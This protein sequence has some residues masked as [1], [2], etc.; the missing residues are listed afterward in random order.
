MC[1]GSPLNLVLPCYCRVALQ[2]SKMFTKQLEAATPMLHVL[3]PVHVCLMGGMSVAAFLAGAVFGVSHGALPIG[4]YS[5]LA[6]A[7]C[8]GAKVRSRPVHKWMSG[9]AGRCTRLL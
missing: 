6:E 7:A 3:R 2:A 1:L 5:M 4:S 8:T 9:C